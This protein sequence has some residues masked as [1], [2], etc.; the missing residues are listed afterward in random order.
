VVPNTP[1]I[2]LNN[3]VELPQLGCGMFKIDDATPVV[4]A[5]L[6]VG[7]PLVDCAASYGNET[8]VG[9]ALRKSGRDR[10]DVFVTSK[11]PNSMQGYARTLAAFDESLGRLGLEY[12][13]LYL[14]HWPVP[15]KDQYVDTWR[16]MAEIYASGRARAVGVSNFQPEH[17]RRLAESSDLVPAVNQIELHPGYVQD[18]LRALHEQMHIV[19][20]AWSPLGRGTALLDQT[21]VM[22]IAAAHDR[23]AAQ[24]VIRWHLDSGHALIP[25]S[26][27]ANRLA[28]NF[29]VFDFGLSDAERATLSELDAPGRVGPDPQTFDLH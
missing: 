26:V 18:E 11:V 20:Q 7:Y 16:A 17:L 19:T 27:S 28:E 4:L 3:G 6:A 10:A 12:L 8:G 13:D 1:T 25:K 15:A 23:T 22:R 24:V 29:D 14:I 2:R 5:A 9:A 21:A